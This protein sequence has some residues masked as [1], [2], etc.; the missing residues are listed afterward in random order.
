MKPFILVMIGLLL[1]ICTACVGI[2]TRGVVELSDATW[3]VEI[4]YHQ[5]ETWTTLTGRIAAQVEMDNHEDWS[6]YLSL[7][8]IHHIL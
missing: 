8:L 4:D 3:D 1:L 5:I 2:G 6:A 7:L